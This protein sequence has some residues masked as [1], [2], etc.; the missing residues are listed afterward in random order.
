MNINL[1]ND[2]ARATGAA[3]MT[4]SY[5]A[6]ANRRQ[7]GLRLQHDIYLNRPQEVVLTQKKRVILDRR[8]RSTGFVS[9]IR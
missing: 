3:A 7:T 8:W 5:R 1:S 2:N 9:F 4:I 6:V